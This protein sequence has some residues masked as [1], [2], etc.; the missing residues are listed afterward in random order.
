MTPM[1]V[2]IGGLNGRVH[3]VLSV[4]STLFLVLMPLFRLLLPVAIT[5]V[6]SSSLFIQYLYC[7]ADSRCVCGALI[8][9]PLFGDYILPGR[10]FVFF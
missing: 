10:V 3:N 9:N 2:T 6:I 8:F 1:G 7:F 4:C 5:V